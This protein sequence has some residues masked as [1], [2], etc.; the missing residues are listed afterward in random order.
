MTSCLIQGWGEPG[1]TQL[2]HCE[3]QYRVGLHSGILVE[4]LYH[5]SLTPKT[6]EDSATLRLGRN[7]LQ[8]PLC[9]PPEGESGARAEPGDNYGLRATLERHR[10]KQ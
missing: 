8:S 10:R 5:T 1:R 3:D 2:P 7:R 6:R 9:A 4:S